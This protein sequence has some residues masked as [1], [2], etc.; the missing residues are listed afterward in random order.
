MAR[1]YPGK[2]DTERRLRRACHVLLAIAV[3]FSGFGIGHAAMAKSADGAHQTHG[4]LSGV[5]SA[6]P[7]HQKCHDQTPAQDQTP[8][9]SQHDMGGCCVNACFS[10]ALPRDVLSFTPPAF[11]IQKLQPSTDQAPALTTPAGLFRPPRDR[12]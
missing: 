9:P 8:P 5:Q 6:T 11:E 3:L 12:A 4:T 1:T 7:D 10:P 2:A